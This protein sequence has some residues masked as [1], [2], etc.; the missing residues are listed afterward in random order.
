LNWE[1]REVATSG[2][3][4]ALLAAALTDVAAKP[5]TRGRE[6]KKGAHLCVR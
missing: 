1:L 2:N 3:L 4:E 6:T 5:E